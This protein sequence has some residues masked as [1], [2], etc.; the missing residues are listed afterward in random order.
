MLDKNYPIIHIGFPKTGSTTL[1]DH[2]F[3]YLPNTEI[4]GQPR[5]RV[6]EG[7]Q[8]IIHALTDCETLEFD[9]EK[10]K[11]EIDHIFSAQ[12]LIVSEETFSTGS[13]LSGRVSRYEIAHRLKSLFPHSKVVV[14]IR[15]Q[16]S[17]IRS[18][19]LQSRKINKGA[20]PVFNDW[21]AEAAE[22]SHKENIFQYFHY[23]KIIAVYE[24]LFGHKNIKIVLFEDF[25]N[26]R[27]SFFEELLRFMDYE[28]SPEIKKILTRLAT[29][30]ENQPLT[31][32]QELFFRL[33][34]FLKPFIK[35]L[36]ANVKKRLLSFLNRGKNLQVELNEEQQ[37]AVFN[38]Y[39]FGNAELMKNYKLPL[40]KYKYALDEN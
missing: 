40:D 3:N 21:F 13:S 8:K 7:I 20:I 35:L 38:L 23:G 5:S 36:N 9:D 29:A 15:E 39:A 22:N 37:Q 11:G 6:D 1:Q 10:V 34:P 27:A 31:H 12:R 14:V 17:I 4:L 32:R 25:V 24:K 2:L 16:Q 26:N 19:Y 18:F 30:H 28:L 33:R